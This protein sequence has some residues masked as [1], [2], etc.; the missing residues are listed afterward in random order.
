MP[1]KIKLNQQIL[2]FLVATRVVV[3]EAHLFNLHQPS[4]LIIY[5]F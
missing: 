4:W 1:K 3:I 5:E 2:T